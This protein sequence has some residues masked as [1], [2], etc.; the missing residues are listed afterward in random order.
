MEKLHNIS[1]PEE[2]HPL[3]KMFVSDTIAKL[4]K[5]KGFDEPCFAYYELSYTKDE[6]N[7]YM[8]GERSRTGGYDWYVN[9]VGV[10]LSNSE[11]QRNPVGRLKQCF[12]APMYWQIQGW[13]RIKRNIILD[14]RYMPKLNAWI[15]HIYNTD[16]KNYLS[17]SAPFTDYDMAQEQ[18][19]LKVLTLIK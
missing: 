11:M 6:Y 19:L 5:E 15:N 17:I 3:K 7:F 18:I 4:L 10:G 13:L 14:I 16:E 12:T 8:V 1:N 9:Y 2:Q